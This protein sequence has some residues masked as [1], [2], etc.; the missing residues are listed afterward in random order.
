MQ[1]EQDYEVVQP[2]ESFK[3]KRYVEWVQDWSNWFYKINPD[4]NNNGDVVFLRGKSLDGSYLDN[5]GVVKVGSEALEISEDQAILIPII[6]AN[7]VACNQES[8]ETLY[9][10]VRSHI[11]SGDH[12]P[13]PEQLR[14]NGKPIK[15][16]DLGK[17]EI[18]TPPFMISIP[19]TSGG[20]IS[21][22][23][24][25]ETPIIPSGLFQS[26][27]RGY[28]VM[29]K[30]KA[31]V[32]DYYIECYANGATTQYGPYN[33]SLLYHII[34]K[35]STFQPNLRIPPSRLSKNILTKVFEKHKNGELSGP[36]YEKIKGYLEGSIDGIENGL[37]NFM[38]KKREME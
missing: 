20:E 38:L 5:E 36:E 12:P 2:N 17:F 4:H 19:D 24:R 10:M 3:S 34:V 22:K 9:G 18:E 31:S 35:K 14:I 16:K 11:F 27:T 32:K 30:L 26:V 1:N 33:V 28:F 37:T 6:T 23:D 29:L 13:I 15:E 8:P 21:L 25:M 7:Y